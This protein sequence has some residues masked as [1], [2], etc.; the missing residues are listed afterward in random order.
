MP[1]AWSRNLRWE[2]L[3]LHIIEERIFE[4]LL[5]I[6][7]WLPQGVSGTSG[8]KLNHLPLEIKAGFKSNQ[9]AAVDTLVSIGSPRMSED[10]D[11]TH[12]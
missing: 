11:F 4:K 8:V 9:L 5:C 12:F 7:C 3:G 1:L 2:N 6:R 10:N